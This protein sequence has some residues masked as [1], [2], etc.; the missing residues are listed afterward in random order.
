MNAKDF[1]TRPDH[2]GIHVY[3]LDEATKW[4]HDVFD[5]GLGFRIGL[6]IGHFPRA[7]FHLLG[8]FY[9]EIYEVRNPLPF[10]F[11]DYENS[12]GVK[13]AELSCIDW[14]GW[15]QNAID[16]G[17][18]FIYED[19]TPGKEMA[20]V[21]GIADVPFQVSRDTLGESEEIKRGRW[22]MRVSG[23]KVTCYNIEETAAWYGEIFGYESLQILPRENFAYPRMGQVMNNNVRLLMME[24]PEAAPLNLYDFENNVG[25]KHIDFGMKD[26]CGWQEYAKEADS[27]M[28]V[29][30]S[31][32][33]PPK[34]DSMVHYVIDNNGMLTEMSDEMFYV[35]EGTK[36]MDE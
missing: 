31:V 34:G 11:D 32:A 8:D 18:E 19:N 2:V 21:K 23:V 14:E 28:P 22:G 24:T 29:I 1:G 10:S 36:R 9:F 30:V 4:C 5:F 6:P 7:A 20:V 16:Y 3:S 35:P 33:G 25:I 17:V 13:M 12:I 15:K 27:K 26:R